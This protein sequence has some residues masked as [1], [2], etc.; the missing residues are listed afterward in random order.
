MKK[1]LAPLLV[2][3]L[4]IPQVSIAGPFFT[5]TKVENQNEFIE[6]TLNKIRV[7]NRKRSRRYSSH[8][9]EELH[10]KFKEDMDNLQ[11]LFRDIE[12]TTE[13]YSTKRIV[14]EKLT[15]ITER[16]IVRNAEL[17]Q[18]LEDAIAAGTDE[19]SFGKRTYELNKYVLILSGLT[20]AASLI[21]AT[22]FG[23][24]DTPYTKAKKSIKKIKIG[25]LKTGITGIVI[26]LAS[27]NVD[28]LTSKYAVKENLVKRL[29][30]ETNLSSI[31]L[32]QVL[33]SLERIRGNE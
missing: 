26:A 22:A 9:R 29:K 7:D 12:N 6:D 25:L 21:L 14:I 2:T 23:M 33:S 3:T 20:P 27:L 8:I 24:V 15:G 30:L 11:S 32:K 18:E 4:L 1:L 17:N 16:L 28:A 13:S 5:G 10:E 31:T 19:D